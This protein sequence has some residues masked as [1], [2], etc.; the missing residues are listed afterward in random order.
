MAAEK[1]YVLFTRDNLYQLLAELEITVGSRLNTAM[2]VEAIDTRVDQWRE[3]Y[4][5]LQVF[6]P[7]FRPRHKEKS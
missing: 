4:S 6:Y 5:A 1:D 2:S 3:H 7:D